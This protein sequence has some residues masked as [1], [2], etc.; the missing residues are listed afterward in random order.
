MC[1]FFFGGGGV[2]RYVKYTYS[3]HEPALHK[4]IGSIS[5]SRTVICKNDHDL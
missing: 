5:P 3:L 4:H 2:R 1:V